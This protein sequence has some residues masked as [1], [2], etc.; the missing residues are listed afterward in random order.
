M[1]FNIL[2]EF[3]SIN[4]EK[5]H[6]K[7]LKARVA[8]IREQL[9]SSFKMLCEGRVDREQRSQPWSQFSKQRRW[10]PTLALRA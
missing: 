1:M 9:Q 10:I 3:K 8:V 4:L 7:V 2:N 5:F 6:H